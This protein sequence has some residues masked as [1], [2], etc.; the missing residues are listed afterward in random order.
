MSVRAGTSL[1]AIAF[2]SA[3]PARRSAKQGFVR[4]GDESANLIDAI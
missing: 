3:R 2:E 1:P 4:T